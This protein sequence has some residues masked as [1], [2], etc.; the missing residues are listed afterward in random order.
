MGGPEFRGPEPT[1]Q[2]RD[3]VGVDNGR[4][5][6]L[7]AILHGASRVLAENVLR[8][9]VVVMAFLMFAYA[10]VR[11]EGPWRILPGVAFAVLVLWPIIYRERRR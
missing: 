11:V 9:V 3:Y 5:Y 7:I 8:S 2:H 10:T 6:D 1:Q 4:P